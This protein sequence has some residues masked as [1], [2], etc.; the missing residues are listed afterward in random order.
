[1]KMILSLMIVASLAM[2]S[3]TKQSHGADDIIQQNKAIEDNP[4]GGGGNNT[5]SVPSAVL[6]AF[7]TRYPSATQ[8]QWKLLSDGTYKAEFF[9]GSVKWQAIFTA[10][11][12][13]VKEQHA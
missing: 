3:C 9:I 6:S 1:M 13:L 8:V 7:S 4:N 10:S 12:T 11:G 5:M 2:T